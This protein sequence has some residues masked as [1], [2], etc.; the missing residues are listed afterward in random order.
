MLNRRRRFLGYPRVWVCLWFIPLG[1][2]CSD[3]TDSSQNLLTILSY[4]IH[5]GE[6]MDRRIDLE[7]IAAVIQLVTPDIVALQ[8]VDR[9]TGRSGRIDQAAELERLTGLHAIFGRSID[10]DDGQYGNAVLTRLLVVA[11]HVHPLPTTP[12][13]EARTVLLLELSLLERDAPQTD[14]LFLA[15]HF[16]HTSDETDRLASVPAIRSILDGY[17]LRMPAI[18]AGDLNAT[19]ASRTIAQLRSLWIFAGWGTELPTIPVENPLQQI[20][21]IA[22]RPDNAWR[23]N[24]IRVL[25]EQI[26]SDHRPIVATLERINTSNV[27]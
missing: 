27:E 5:H 26:A 13:R 18:L 23:V 4:N 6:G 19:I 14:L 25:D 24:E 7:R 2:Y 11:D 17:D 15:T 3:S 22:F 21:Y 8:E 9:N 10:Y 16:D 12:G 20:D 1:V